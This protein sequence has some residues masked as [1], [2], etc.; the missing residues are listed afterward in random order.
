MIVTK[1][2][3]LVPTWPRSSYQPPVYDRRL[4]TSTVFF[5]N[6]PEH[7]KEKSACTFRSD[8]LLSYKILRRVFNTD[9]AE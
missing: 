8:T 7:A 4:T 3:I 6:E 5:S 1:M 9:E 2:K